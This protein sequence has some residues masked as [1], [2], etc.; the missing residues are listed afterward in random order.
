MSRGK[1]VWEIIRIIKWYIPILAG[2]YKKQKTDKLDFL[3]WL[4]SESQ[5]ILDIIRHWYLKTFIVLIFASLANEMICWQYLWHSK[6]PL[7]QELLPQ[8]DLC[9]VQVFH[10]LININKC[11]TETLIS[12]S[13]EEQKNNLIIS[14]H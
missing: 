9:L 4:R 2:W 3:F 1:N 6:S 7:L 14:V 10:A 5:P 11:L 8:S 12:T 13:N